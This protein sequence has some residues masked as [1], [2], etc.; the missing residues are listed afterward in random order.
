M[1][2]IYSTGGREKYFKKE[3]V[4]DCVVR[5]ICNATGLDYKEVYDNINLLAKEERI[6]KRKKGISSARNGVYKSTWKKYL[7]N[8]GWKWR[9]CMG[10]GTGCTTHLCEEEL[11]KGT[12]IVQVS[13]HLTCVKN[14]ILYDTYDCTR[15][16]TR[17]VYG[18]Y[19]KA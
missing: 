5:A 6:T 16:G 13:K 19:Y 12:L 14:G 17:C 3:N 11:P 8:L 2:L 18:Y 15:G 10:I 1:E 4:G 9:S 7:E